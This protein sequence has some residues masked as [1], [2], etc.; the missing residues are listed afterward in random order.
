MRIAKS[1]SLFK[2]CERRDKNTCDRQFI[3]YGEILAT[4]R[5]L[6]DCGINIDNVAAINNKIDEECCIIL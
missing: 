2:L 1:K 4:S 3:A 6:V 5:Y